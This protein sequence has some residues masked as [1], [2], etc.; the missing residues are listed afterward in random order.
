MDLAYMAALPK[1]E[2][3]QRRAKV[4]EQMQD[5][6]LF[7]VFSD[8]ERRRNDGCDYPFRQDSYFWYLTGFNEP[9]SALLLRKQQGEQQAIIFVRPSDKLLE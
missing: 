8:I 7:L 5:D 3:A 4:F 9:N 1:E 2:F 6:S